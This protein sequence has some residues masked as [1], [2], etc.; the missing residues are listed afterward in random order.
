MIGTLDIR[1]CDCM[2][3]MREFPDK[4]F[5]LAIVDPPY[6]IGESGASNHTRCKMAV[7]K[8][9]KAFSGNDDEPPPP[10]YYAELRR[11]SINQIIFG[12]NH[13]ADRMPWPSPCWI[14]WDKQNGTSDFA[15][16]ELAWT[17][18]KSAVRKFEFR[19]AGMLQ[20]NMAEK[21][22]RIHPTQKP[23]ALYRWLL[24]NYAKPG[25]Q[26]LDTHLGSGSI[27]IACHYF[28]AH[29]TA[30][31]ID[32]DY[33]AAAVARI[34]RD[35]SQSDMFTASNDPHILNQPELIEAK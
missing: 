32:P 35:T 5:D 22:H 19:W 29:L 15:D 1:L 31:E 4:H 10:E 34:E 7:A 28:G 25:Q 2:D 21:E 20:G 9:Y 14:V 18:F 13:F 12:A 8:N 16:C 26:I 27:A 6:G 30:S 23:V 11:V 3:L 33:Y 24:A 17:S